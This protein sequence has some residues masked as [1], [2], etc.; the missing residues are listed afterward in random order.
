M[1]GFVFQ[2]AT[3]LGW[4][5][6]IDNVALPLEVLHLSKRER[7]SRAQDLLELVGLQGFERHYPDQVSGGMQQRASIARALSFR[8]SVLLMDEP[9]EHST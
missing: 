7:R 3:L 8:P 1:F 9:P 5:T 6:L 4:R 2:E